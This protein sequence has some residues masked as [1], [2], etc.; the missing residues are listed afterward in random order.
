MKKLDV[1]IIKLDPIQVASFHAYSA[2]PED[3]AKQKLINW[4]KPKGL[5]KNPGKHRIFGFNNP[6]PSPGSPNYGYEFW[7]TI[8]PEIKAQKGATI[9]DFPGG[10]YAVMRCEVRGN[11]YDIIPATWKQLTAWCEGN[12]QYHQVAHQYL[13]EAIGPFIVSNDFTLDLYLPIRE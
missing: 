7:I 10:L 2:S 3:E 1:K 13:E 12:N 11:A 8:G 5:F 6:D 9:K 4:A